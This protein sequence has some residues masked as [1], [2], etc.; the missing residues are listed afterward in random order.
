M[1]ALPSLFSGQGQLE[2]AFADGLEEMLRQHRGLGVYI[3]VLANAAYDAALWRRFEAPLAARH[4]ELAAALTERLRT[5][6]PLQE[7][8]DDVVVFLKLMAIGFEHV[9]SVQTREPG[10]WQLAFNPVRALRPPRFS[11]QRLTGL[12]RPFDA[13][14]FHFNKPFLA[15]EVFWQGLLAGKPARMLY[16]KFPFARL[17]GLLVPEPA[18]ELPQ[19]LTEAL[20]H[21]AWECSAQVAVPGFCLAY[22]SLGAGASVNHMH[23]QSFVQTEPLPVQRADFRHN[24][25]DRAYPLPCLRFEDATQAWD[26]LD[27]LNRNN[28]TY[29]L[30][31]GQQVLHLIPRKPQGTESL[32]A[33][34]NGYGWIDMA[35]AINLFTREEFDGMTVADIEAELAAFA[36]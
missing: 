31:Y 28:Q 17:H 23:F 16:N 20:H 5:N 25:G 18:S 24:G 35:G 10:N 21:W 12:L 1:S 33:R 19:Y 34:A 2:H 6:A 4:A 29:N 9:E 8:E 36:P 3:L 22:N 32:N 11:G 14:G 13:C 27:E 30:L 7:P 15:R 26:A